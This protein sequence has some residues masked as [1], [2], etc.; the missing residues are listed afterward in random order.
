MIQKIEVVE[1]DVRL[2]LHK[3]ENNEVRIEVYYIDDSGYFDSED[4]I[5]PFDKIK[6]LLS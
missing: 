3:P 5:I 4:F 1:N 6:K 2:V